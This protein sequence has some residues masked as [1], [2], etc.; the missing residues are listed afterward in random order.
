MKYYGNGMKATEFTRKQINVIFAKA[1][2][3]DLKV[4]KWYIGHLYDMADFYSYDENGSAEKE[5]SIIKVLLDAVFAGRI[6]E[7]QQI[8]SSETDRRFDLLSNKNQK[9]ANRALVA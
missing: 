4:E 3:G 6:E 8:I 9:A 5:E 2:K 1:K 7:A